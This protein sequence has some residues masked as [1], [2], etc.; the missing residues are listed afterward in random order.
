MKLFSSHLKLNK[1]QAE[2]DFVDVPVGKDLP[3]FI[4]PFALSLRQDRWSQRAHATL[5]SFF[6]KIIEF[7]RSGAL[8]SARQLLIHLKEPNETRLGL[9]KKR[10]SGR[11][12]GPDQA[13]DLFNALRTSSAVRTGFLKSLEE[14]ELLVEG[15]G[16]DKISDLTTNVIRG[17]LAEYTRDQC[18][19]WGVPVQSLPVGPYYSSESGEWKSEFLEMPIVKGKPILLVP[20]AIVRFDPAYNHQHYYRQIVLSY[21][22]AEHMHANTALVRTLK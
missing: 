4:D 10:P 12:I 13:N 17:H 7:I 9:S 11:G 19:L 18:E 15:I 6:E 14:C 20:K 5:I 3:L 21:L 2:L 16:R 8:E 1:T 22:Q